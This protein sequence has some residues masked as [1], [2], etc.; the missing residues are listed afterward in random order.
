MESIQFIQGKSGCWFINFDTMN[1]QYYS[2]NELRS[3]SSR[4]DFINSVS[5]SLSGVPFEKSLVE[6]S[7]LSTSASIQIHPSYLCNYK[8]SYCY[9]NDRKNDFSRLTIADLDLIDEFYHVFDQMFK[10]NTKIDGVTIS[11]G[12]PFLPGNRPFL[13][14]ALSHWENS[15]I[16][17]ITNGVFLS[18]YIPLLSTRDNL[19]LSVSLD[20]TEIMHY[21]YRK[22]NNPA[23]YS[24]TI[25]GI[26]NALSAGIRVNIS[27]VFHPDL[28]SYY[29]D[30]FDYIEA[31]GW[32]ENPNVTLAFGLESSGV[33]SGSINTDYLSQS[34]D[35]L[36]SIKD[37]DP[38]INHFDVSTLT[39]GCSNIIRAITDA[40]NGKY[41]PYRCY[42]LN[43]P[44][45]SFFPNGKVSFCST[46]NQEIGYIGQIRPSIMIDKDK[47]TLLRSR[48]INNLSNC[49]TCNKRIICKGN[50]PA[51]SIAQTNSFWGSDCTYWKDDTIIKKSFN[52]LELQ[53]SFSNQYINK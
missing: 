14:K 46:I 37:N 10:T 35:A 1:Y 42:I 53:N 33:G 39:P 43:T 3:F 34:L 29:S 20:G 16:A 17:I 23:S 38:R 32:F 41:N 36:K 5:Q 51:T 44:S 19:H 22:T 11:G 18:D 8:C 52:F 30:F 48:T 9:E 26:Q 13:E 49:Q 15:T 45:F 27:S 31:L 47:I 28:L 25:A 4:E 24:L 40:K 6:E 2:Y 7:T 21:K 12:E 50:C